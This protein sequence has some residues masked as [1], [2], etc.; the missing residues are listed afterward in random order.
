MIRGHIVWFDHNNVILL[1]KHFICISNKCQ[2][3]IGI[4]A[5]SSDLY[6]SLW[7]TWSRLYINK[8]RTNAFNPYN[9]VTKFFFLH[10]FW[11]FIFGDPQ[12]THIH[13]IDVCRPWITKWTNLISYFKLDGDVIKLPIFYNLMAFCI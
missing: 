1:W 13:S 2:I 8:L 5:F 9:S 7:V 3:I 6:V 10:L 4:N 12:Y 11:K